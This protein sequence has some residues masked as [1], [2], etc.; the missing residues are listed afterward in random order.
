[1]GYQAE[2]DTVIDVTPNFT[3]TDITG[4]L[5]SNTGLAM[6]LQGGVTD[7]Y[8]YI[9]QNP[10]NFHSFRADGTIVTFTTQYNPVSTTITLNA[11]PNAFYV[12]GVA[13]ALTSITNVGVATLAAAGAAGTGDVLL[14]QTLFAN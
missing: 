6:T 9:T 8:N 4:A 5:F 7:N 13:T 14:Y 10:L 1:M 3:N 12:G 11:T 2:S